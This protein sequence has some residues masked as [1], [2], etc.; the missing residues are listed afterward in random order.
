MEQTFE[1]MLE[2]LEKVVKKLE[3]KE[4]ALDDAVKEYKKGLELA[5]ACYTMLENAE[6]VLVKTQE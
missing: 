2:Q 1:A 5:K 4:I 3:T 6:K